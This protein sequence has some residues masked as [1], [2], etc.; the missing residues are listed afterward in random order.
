MKLE[1]IR[2]MTVDQRLNLY[3]NASRLGT[4]DAKAV[5]ELMIEYDLLVTHTGGF[6]HDHP[7][8]MQIEDIIRSPEGRLLIK[9][10]ADRG[11]PALAGV[12][13]VIT[14][15]LGAAYGPFDTTSWAGTF[16]ADEMRK[17]GYLKD[18]QK[19]LPKGSTAKTGALF[20]DFR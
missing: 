5:V 2:A 11:L 18:G 14:E 9:D 1:Q 13:L 15:R 19:A 10:A 6:P 20:R 8:I 4:D 12:D 16:V 3:R 7:V 17:L